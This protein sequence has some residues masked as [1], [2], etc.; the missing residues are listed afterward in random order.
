MRQVFFKNVTQLKSI[1]AK[2]KFLLV[3]CG[4][5]RYTGLDKF[6]DAYD[7]VDFS[8]FTPN[9]LYEQVCAG[10]ELFKKENCELIVAIG[11]GSAIDVAKCIKLY[12]KMPPEENYLKQSP[13]CSDVELVAIPTTAGTGSES[14]KHAVIYFAGEKQSISHPEIIP[15]YVVLDASS[16]KSLP[17]Y[18][19]KCTMM[20]ALCQAIE[21]Y[22][23]VK[24][25]KE[26]KGYS[27]K[28]IC[29]IKENWEKYIFENSEIAASKIMQA[30]NYSG[31]AINITATTAAHAMSYKITSLY[32]FPH[33]HAV[34][35]CLGQ[36]WD[37]MLKNTKNCSDPRGFKYLENTLSEIENIITPDYF[38]SMLDK[39]ELAFP[40]STKKEEDLKLLA[41]SV[42]PVRLGNNPVALDVETL[43]DMYKRIVL[44]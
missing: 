29:A 33:G 7:Y 24:S 37:Y 22:W 8:D 15:N 31:R 1:L 32:G 12:C 10:V 23:A 4:S 36:V 40:I 18:Q 38:N 42:N 26:S 21:S 14:T 20:D 30:A 27:V 16:L 44:E 11:G 19:K 5:F 13:V 28:A 2:R 34:A 39:L 3:N 25:N 43:K 35:V 9:P 6:F 41:L 17:V